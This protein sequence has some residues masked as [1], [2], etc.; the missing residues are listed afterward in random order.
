MHAPRYD[1]FAFPSLWETLVNLFRAAT[2]E[3][4]SDLMYVTLY[5]CDPV[6]GYP[7]GPPRGRWLCRSGGAHAPISRV[8]QILA[9]FYWFAFIIVAS[10]VMLSLFI[11]AITLGMQDSVDEVLEEKKQAEGT[12]LEERRLRQADRMA[13][14][15]KLAKVQNLWKEITRSKDSSSSS[16]RRPLADRALTRPD[17]SKGG[18][19]GDGSDSGASVDV[20]AADVLAADAHY[21]D[22]AAK[23]CCGRCGMYRCGVRYMRLAQVMSVVEESWSFRL[24]M[25]LTSAPR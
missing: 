17:A 19:R 23:E 7:A 16:R 12:R 25:L 24:L 15:G 2:L 13:K 1:P 20:L 10:F 3:D 6:Y 9:T 21:E 14:S 8:D 18:T 4:W 22:E 5:G 11:G